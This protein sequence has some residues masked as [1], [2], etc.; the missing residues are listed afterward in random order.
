MLTIKTLLSDYMSAQKLLYAFLEISSVLQENDADLCGRH[1]SALPV[2]EI[3][4]QESVARA[5]L[6]LLEGL[7]VLHQV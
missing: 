7:G 6:E 2:V 5:E 1:G 3:K 4:L